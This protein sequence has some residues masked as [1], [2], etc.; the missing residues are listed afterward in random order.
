[1]ADIFISY[2][3]EDRSRILPLVQALEGRFSVWFDGTSIPGTSVSE[4]VTAELNAARCVLV[5]WSRASVTAERGYKSRWLANEAMEGTRKPK[6]LVPVMLD[7]GCVPIIHQDQNYMDLVGWAG[8]QTDP[9]LAS[10]LNAF[11]FHL[12]LAGGERTSATIPLV[13]ASV[14]EPVSAATR[15][16]IARAAHAA[17][18]GQAVAERAF[19][20][21]KAGVA[22]WPRQG[23]IALPPGHFLM[24]ATNDEE[25]SEDFER[26]LHRVSIDYVFALGRRPVTFNEWDAAQASEKSLPYIDDKGWGRGPRPVINV[27]WEDAQAY[28]A[29]LNRELG[30]RGRKN[31]FRLP[32]EAEWEYA[33]RARTA[34]PFSTGLN[35]AT[36]QA[37]FDGNYSYGDQKTNGAY[38]GRT[39]PVASFEQNAYGLFDMHGNVWEWCAD[40]WVDHY[41]SAP[42]TGSAWLSGDDPVVRVIRGGSWFNPPSVLRSAARNWHNSSSR[43][44][45]VGFRLAMTL[46][47]ETVS[48]A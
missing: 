4:V 33:C 26:P 43:D 46:A 27:S 23:M 16:A 13:E 10:L 30:L 21:E 28:L 25:G 37:N 3:R 20:I 5:V 31:V 2:K 44:E 40:T 6:I 45:F 42:T 12:G 22:G 48:P 7:E 19:E 38:V 18:T 41:W 24:G 1:M 15:S 36:N 29:W 11:A 32:S 35:I 47:A 34:T 14:R 17:L 8:D 9:R 39:L